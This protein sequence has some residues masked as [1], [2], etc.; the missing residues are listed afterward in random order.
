MAT[1]ATRSAPPGKVPPPPPPLKKFGQQLRDFW[2]RM[3][4]GVQLSQMWA[5]FR[6]DTRSSYDFY[7]REVSTEQGQLKGFHRAWAI[8]K[9][10]F[11]SIMMKLSPARRVA[12]LLALV[13]LVFPISQI[14]I[15]DTYIDTEFLKVIGTLLLLFL[16]LLEVADRV[17]LKRDLQIA[18]EIQLWLVPNAPPPVPGLELAF[19]NRPANTVAGDYYDVFPRH[20]GGEDT[21]HYIIIVADVAG[22]SLP[23]ALLMA[24][25][26]ASLQTLAAL[27]GTL[28]E[29]VGRLNDYACKNSNSGARFTTAFIAEYDP[30][31][32]SLTYINAGQN[33]P[34]V[35]TD[36]RHLLRLTEGGV[37]LG[38][39]PGTDYTASKLLLHPDDLMLIFTDGVVEAVTERLEEYGEPRLIAFAQ[40]AVGPADQILKSLQIELDTYVGPARQHD[41]MTCVAVRAR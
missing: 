13:L 7:S 24:T 36:A 30:A 11:W 32:R 21:G 40:R 28:P 31:S 34:I 10:V 22:K 12:L 20:I 14:R 26:Q 25:L 29:L 16:L 39:K 5:Q 4:E 19:M 37:P 3:T 8:A 2:Q 6:V 41:D 33:A 35:I 23:A 9:Q 27:P 17:T 15:G 18:R 1:T 38:I